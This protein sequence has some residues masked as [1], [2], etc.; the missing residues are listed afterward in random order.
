[1]VEPYEKASKYT[2][3]GLQQ[4]WKEKEQKQ[5]KRQGSKVQ[6]TFFS[7]LEKT[8]WEEEEKIF[9]GGKVPSIL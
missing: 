8:G 7:A 9:T 2:Y 6:K 3:P 4:S 5:K 1:M